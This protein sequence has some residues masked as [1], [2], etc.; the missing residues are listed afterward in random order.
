MRF[1]IFRKRNDEIEDISDAPEFRPIVLMPNPDQT[2]T[3]FYERYWGSLELTGE[4]FTELVMDNGQLIGMYPLRSDLM[5]IVPGKQGEI[6]GYIQEVNAVKI[7]FEPE[8]IWMSKYWNP[9]SDIRGLSPLEAATQTIITEL[10]SITYNRSKLDEDVTPTGIFS[11]K[12][13]I[14]E[15]EYDRVKMAFKDTYAGAKAAY[16]ILYLDHDVTY[17]NI[18]LSPKDMEYQALRKMSKQEIREAF[19]VPPILTQD[20]SDSSVLQNT[21]VQ[22][23]IFW[24]MNLVPKLLK[25]QQK[26]NKDLM[27]LMTDDKEVFAAYD[28]SHIKA[29]QK[30]ETEKLE[31]TQLRFNM[32]AATPNEVREASG[33]ESYEGGDQFFVPMNMIP[34]QLSGDEGEGNLPKSTQAAYVKRGIWFKG[35]PQKRVDELVKNL[36]EILDS[37]MNGME[38]TV[39]KF[40]DKQ[41]KTAVS[42]ARNL[43]AS[44]FEDARKEKGLTS[45]VLAGNIIEI[46]LGSQVDSVSEWRDSTNAHIRAFVRKAG[47]DLLQLLGSDEALDLLEPDIITQIGSRL[48]NTSNQ[49]WDT[50]VLELRKK[51]QNVIIEGINQGLSVNEM[52]DLVIQALEKYGEE[53]T[54]NRAALIA[55]TESQG[56]GN[57]GRM[58]GMS[59]A[60]FGNHL[61][62][63]SA[64]DRVRNGHQDAN[65]EVVRIGEP[66]PVGKTGTYNGDPSFPSDINERCITIPTTAQITFGV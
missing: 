17:E 22:L 24:E 27:P 40:F 52:K 46:V 45:S 60:G 3:E 30:T 4:A 6:L 55:R 63:T 20:L 21:D 48:V 26:V 38:R 2:I 61:W 44:I 56:M 54:D 59:Q 47:T 64:D 23:R 39:K 1:K 32:G 14:S 25:D 53:I 18:T 29:L 28:F 11:A 51:V 57:F 31:S 15:D 19:G 12:G 41:M 50:T 10:K 49:V 42:R 34:I 36:L 7:P 16:K 37:E 65:G 66:F 43:S 62:A 58:R 33:D 13:Q 35:F 8:E 9:L 5:S